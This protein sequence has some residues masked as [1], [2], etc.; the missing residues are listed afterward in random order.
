MSTP[1]ARW[2]VSDFH[3]DRGIHL[4]VPILSESEWK[5]TSV[6]PN[7][8]LS[9]EHKLGSS[10][11][12]G[13]LSTRAATSVIELRGNDDRFKNDPACRD[14][15]TRKAW[16]E[17]SDPS[18]TIRERTARFGRLDADLPN[19][20]KT[21][22]TSHF[23]LLWTNASD[24]ADDNVADEAL[25]DEA[26]LHLEDAWQLFTT[27]FGRDPYVPQ[28]KQRIQVAFKALD[29]FGQAEPPDGPIRFDSRAWCQIPGMRRP[30]ATH[31][32]FHKLQYAYGYRTNPR[33]TL[34]GPWFAEGTASL[35]EA[36][37]CGTLSNANKLLSAF[38]RPFQA[39]LQLSYEALPFW[40]YF[41]DRFKQAGAEPIRVMLEKFESGGDI[42]EAIRQSAPTINAQSG[43]KAL[44]AIFLEFAAKRLDAAYWAAFALKGPDG[45]RLTPTL[46]VNDVA[47]T[48]Q[49]QD[50]VK[51]L[52]Q[53]GCDY[54][55]L[56]TTATPGTGNVTVD[57]KAQSGECAAQLVHVSNGIVQLSQAIAV[58]SHR[59]IQVVQGNE[60]IVMLSGLTGMTT[61]ELT[62]S[63]S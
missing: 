38:E 63:G 52:Q 56:D 43:L 37:F 18:L 25:I 54:L 55:R 9:R 33:A 14:S 22:T 39:L 59:Q 10:G 61:Y 2:Q 58:P 34:P 3:A 47:V 4:A 26:G 30:T 42:T 8:G 35:A 11:L 1:A 15:I 36:W 7:V 29:S 24:N 46:R 16:L 12:C 48:Q 44:A 5:Q 20:E 31:E 62:V 17:L 51:G 28:G 53:L 27:T 57:T 19:F 13:W 32:L 49:A 21:K 40:M 41:R 45:T 23:E 60:I 6:L 50:I